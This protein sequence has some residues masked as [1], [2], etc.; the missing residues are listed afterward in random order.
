MPSYNTIYYDFADLQPSTVATF[1]IDL[2][3]LSIK[4]QESF[5]KGNL[6]FSVNILLS[7]FSSLK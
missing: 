1:K 4:S 5:G 6:K 2:V 3:T 7:L